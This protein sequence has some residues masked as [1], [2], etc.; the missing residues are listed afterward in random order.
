MEKTKLGLSINLFAALLYFLAISGVLPI[1]I[2]GG[3]VLLLEESHQ[4][5]RT[6][7]KALI[8]T[9]LLSALVLLLTWLSQWLAMT[10]NIFNI[11]IS[12]Y[13]FAGRIDLPL[14]YYLIRFLR[15]VPYSIDSIMRI[16]KILILASF[17]FRTYKQKDI[18]I[19]WIDNILDKH[20]E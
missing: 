14:H 12:F 17:G 2:A 1:M 9:I 20:F 13:H 6:A 4:L 7:I 18:K 11:N 19:K 8:F 15:F 16:I 10:S 3:Y 5:K